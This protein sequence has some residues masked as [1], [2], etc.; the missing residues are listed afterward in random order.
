MDNWS[1]PP[2]VAQNCWP[3]VTL[4]CTQLLQPPTIKG[5]MQYQ[6]AERNKIG[7]RS[8]MHLV[9]VHRTLPGNACGLNLQ[10]TVVVISVT[11]GYPL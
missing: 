8:E 4:C 6:H 3:E 9:K 5:T 10:E 11:A 2:W 7:I 1:M